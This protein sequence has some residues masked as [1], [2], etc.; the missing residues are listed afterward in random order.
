M[1]LC[2]TSHNSSDQ[3]RYG[4]EGGLDKIDRGVKSEIYEVFCA[5]SNW[6]VTTRL[7]HGPIPTVAPALVDS[8]ISIDVYSEIMNGCSPQSLVNSVF[9]VFSRST[10]FSLKSFQKN[11]MHIY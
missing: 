4:G 1:C 5:S 8:L 11:T 6:D 3:L 2:L 9:V 10:V 7:Q